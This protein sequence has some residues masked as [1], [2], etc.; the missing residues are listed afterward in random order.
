MTFRCKK[1]KLLRQQPQNDVSGQLFLA[2][3]YQL[4][5]SLPFLE[6][7]CILNYSPSTMQPCS[8]REASSSLQVQT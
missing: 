3:L 8:V 5:T 1:L 2:T 4:A 7:N 6:D